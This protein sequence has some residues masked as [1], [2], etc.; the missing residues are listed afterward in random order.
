M[1]G[2]TQ[3]VLTSYGSCGSGVAVLNPELKEG[4]GKSRVRNTR[5]GG[6]LSEGKGGGHGGPRWEEVRERGGENLV[7]YLNTSISPFHF[8]SS[9]FYSV[10][11]DRPVRSS[12]PARARTGH[13]DPTKCYSEVAAA[14]THTHES[15]C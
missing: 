8:T 4:G 11:P 9:S 7:I 12:S 13:L 15:R 10:T 14:P 5:L 6:S 2:S 1:G 3:L